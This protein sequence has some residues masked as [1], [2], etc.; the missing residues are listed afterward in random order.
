MLI[1]SSNCTKKI[2]LANSIL[3]VSVIKSDSIFYW[4]AVPNFSVFICVSVIT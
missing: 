1:Q 3:L 2:I 4:Y